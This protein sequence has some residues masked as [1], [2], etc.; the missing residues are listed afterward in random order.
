M[1]LR[2]IIYLSRSLCIA[3]CLLSFVVQNFD[4]FPGVDATKL[5]LNLGRKVGVLDAAGAE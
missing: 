4:T 3:L 1:F 5:R 2:M